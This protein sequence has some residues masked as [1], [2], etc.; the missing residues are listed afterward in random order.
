VRAKR[1]WACATPRWLVKYFTPPARTT[2]ANEALNCCGVVQRNLEVANAALPIAGGGPFRRWKFRAVASSLCLPNPN[3]ASK[4]Y[5]LGNCRKQNKRQP[6]HPSIPLSEILGPQ[7]YWLGFA[8]QVDGDTAHDVFHTIRRA[9]Q[10][11]RLSSQRRAR[12]CSWSGRSHCLRTAASARRS[13]SIAV[14]RWRHCRSTSRSD[15]ENRRRR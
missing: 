13:A 14:R 11:W 4:Q 7:P 15:G 6:P 12:P 2:P 10:G 3:A 5:R 8:P 9:A 1:G